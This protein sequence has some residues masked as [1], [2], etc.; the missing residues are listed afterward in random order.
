V[1]NVQRLGNIDDKVPEIL[2]KTILPDCRFNL[3]DYRSA[4]LTVDD[5]LGCH[6]R[7]TL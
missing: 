6:P 3:I 7:E 2:E 5:E 1:W 4:T